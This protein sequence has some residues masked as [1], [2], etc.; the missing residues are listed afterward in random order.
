[1]ERLADQC[2][3]EPQGAPAC[4]HRRIANA[5]LRDDET[6]VGDERTEGDGALRIDLER[7]QVAVV[8]A[9]EP[10]AALD[11]GPGLALVVRLDEWLKSQVPGV[12]YEAGK[13]L[14]GMKRGEQQ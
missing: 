4:E 6:V 1:D 7:A 12:R 11:G 13:A 10:S 3:V 5:R 14:R 8:E 2:R 9:D